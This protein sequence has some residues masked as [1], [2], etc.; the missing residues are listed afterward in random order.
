MKDRP[1]KFLG[2]NVSK[3]RKAKGFLKAEEFAHRAG[4]AISALKDIERGVSEGHIDTRR[5]ICA[6][7]KCSLEE[8]YHEGGPSGPV[9]DFTSAA[10]F[11]SS[12]QGLEPVLQMVVLAIVH[13]DVGYAADL[14]P[15]FAKKFEPFLEAL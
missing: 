2:L 13:K 14:P 4:I 9:P 11:L 12:F 1:F 8:L 15:E 3:K 7:L 6:T 10:A 5:S